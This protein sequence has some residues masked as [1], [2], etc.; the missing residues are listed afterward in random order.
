MAKKN[1]EPIPVLTLDIV[2]RPKN[3]PRAERQITN[4]DIYREIYLL[5][6][7]VEPMKEWFAYAF[8]P[9]KK[10]YEL[11][12][13][14]ASTLEEATTLIE[15][16]CLE[17]SWKPGTIRLNHILNYYKDENDE[18]KSILTKEFSYAVNR[19][20]IK[21]IRSQEKYFGIN[22]QEALTVA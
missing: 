14:Y 10:D 20:P 22:S 9:F 7:N 21:R 19:Q 16:E 5:P 6:E 8:N 15:E 13:A 17:M 3:Q 1:K 4:M 12:I 11:I 2:S 18:F